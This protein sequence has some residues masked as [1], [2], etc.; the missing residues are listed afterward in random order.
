VTFVELERFDMQ[1]EAAAEQQARKL[2]DAIEGVTAF[3]PKL[4]MAYLGGAPSDGR[5]GE[6]H[7]A[8]LVVAITKAEAKSRARGKW[9]GESRGHVDVIKCV[10]E[11]DRHDVALTPY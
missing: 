2:R 3:E 5:F 7:A 6:D 8:V 10:D 11:V 9:A 4:Y 1:S